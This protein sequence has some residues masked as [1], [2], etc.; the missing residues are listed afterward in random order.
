MARLPSRLRAGTKTEP[1]A[2]EAAVRGAR[3]CRGP[4]GRLRS[5]AV[6]PRAQ[7]H[8]AA[9]T[10]GPK[11]ILAGTR[12]L[13][14]SSWFSGIPVPAVLRDCGRSQRRTVFTDS[15]PPKGAPKTMRLWDKSGTSAHPLCLDQ[16]CG[17]RAPL[18]KGGGW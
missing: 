14:C 4:A 8:G 13:V 15:H 5:L 2:A 1:P 18:D 9:R 3:L 17:I 6:T 11:A 10:A 16:V 12:H 7:G